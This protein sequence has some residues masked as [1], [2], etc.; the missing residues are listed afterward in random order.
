M[1]ISKSSILGLYKSL[2]K[3]GQH[4]KYTDKSYYYDYIRNQFQSVARENPQKIETL[5]KVG[6]F[7][8]FFLLF[9]WGLFFFI[10]PF[11]NIT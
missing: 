11:L 6:N 1:P 2:Y 7:K 5:Y 4:L 9:L 3:Y 8:I 10:L